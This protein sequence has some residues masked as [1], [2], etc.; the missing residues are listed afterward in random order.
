VPATGED[1][2]TIG[3]SEKD[4]A[5]GHYIMTMVGP[6]ELTKEKLNHEGNQSQKTNR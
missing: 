4:A 1:A 5:Y 2:P 6:G 3:I